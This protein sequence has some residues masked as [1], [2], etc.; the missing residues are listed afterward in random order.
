MKVRHSSTCAAVATFVVAL[1]MLAFGQA[2]NTISPGPG[3]RMMAPIPDYTSTSSGGHHYG[4]HV[5]SEADHAVFAQA[6]AV[7]DRGD[8]GNARALAA[9]GKDKIARDLITW[10]YLLDDTSGASFSEIDAFLRAHPAW[11]RREVLFARAEK[12]MPGDMD[13]GSVITWF[14]SR[15][16]SSGWGDV[17]LGAALIKSGK[18]KEGIDRIRKGWVENGFKPEDEIAVLSRYGEHLSSEAHKERLQRLLWTDDRGG[19]ERQMARVD[20]RS[21]RIAETRLKLAR[22]L[23][24]PHA[25]VAKIPESE[26]DDPGILFD[27]AR[28]F[29]RQGEDQKAGETLLRASYGEDARAYALAFWPERHIDARDALRDGRYTLAYNLVSNSKLVSGSEFADAEFL[30]GWIALRFMKNEKRAREHFEKLLAG[31]ATPISK[32]RARYWLGRAEEAIGNKEEAA[33]QYKRAA[34]YGTTFYGQLALARI[35]E[36][37]LLHVKE[38]A[39]DSA[40][41]R[42]SFDADDRTQAMRVLAEF[43]E[44]DLVRLFVA[45]L[46][47]EA[48]DGP[49]MRLLADLMLELN[50]RALAVRAAKQASYNDAY[51][52]VHLY[53][54][55]EVPKVDGLSSPPEPALVLAVARQESEFDPQAV[56]SAGAL[57][58]MQMMPG[59]ARAVANA[60]GMR[61]SPADVT[62]DPKYNLQLGQAHLADFI[63]EWG[64]SYVLAIAS[65]NAGDGNVRRWID[66]YGDPRSPSV[67]PIDWIELIPFG[68]TRN[69]VQ[70]VLENTGV[71]RNRLVGSDQKLGIMTDLYRPREPSLTIIHYVPPPPKA[72][73]PSKKHHEPKAKPKHK[74]HS[75]KAH[76]PE[77]KPATK[78]SSKKKSKSR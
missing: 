63:A 2:Q 32:A 60:H 33:A 48:P 74:G 77:K 11:P 72:E 68:E 4:P 12:A 66:A 19:A 65:Y 69:Y 55:M 5:L 28:A 23:G 26:R 35:E 50:N 18:R 46:M 9:Q 29:R 44:D 70:R 71:Y 25:V 20:A 41:L 3:V 14:G 42:A 67:D 57:G 21:Q 45:R 34:E 38:S 24:S 78:K 53:P 7:A 61:Y 47:L 16:P 51:L 22:G 1:P 40:A 73:K 17:R 13:A 62:T 31:V 52:I 75:S 6:F 58:L 15:E 64:G 36:Q 37:P 8:W 10:Q 54:V 39:S 49:H 59:S 76:E 43:G 56:S 27:E 30:S